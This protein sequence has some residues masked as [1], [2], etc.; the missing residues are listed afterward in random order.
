MS[1]DLAAILPASIPAP[2]RWAPSGRFAPLRRREPAGP[3]QIGIDLVSL[4]KFRRVFEGRPLLLAE[5]F[6]DEERRYCRRQRRPLQHLAA[7][8]AAKEAV[9]KGLESG[10]S[11]PLRWRDVE[12][13]RGPRG[14]PRVILRGAAAGLAAAKGFH[15][16][17]VSLT[18]TED[19][20]LAAVLFSA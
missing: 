11:G 5:V 1:D 19:Y 18:H 8:F 16:C 15:R 14:E 17:A 13:A 9:F 6:T 3:P 20:A 10:L 12:I 4:S 2:R 7:R